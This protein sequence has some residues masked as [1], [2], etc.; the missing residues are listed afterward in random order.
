MKLSEWRLKLTDGVSDKLKRIAGLS[1]N[2]AMRMSNLQDR[3][4]AQYS[5]AA[6]SV[7]NITGNI[8]DSLSDLVSSFTGMSGS[9]L[10]S[11]TNPFIIASVIVAGLGIKAT[12]MAMQ[13]EQGM[14]KVNATAQMTS[15]ELGGLRKE[16]IDIGR[17]SA[18]DMQMLPSS[19]EKINSQ[20]NNTQVSLEVLKASVKAADAGFA[21]LDVVSGAVARTMNLV[22]K[23]GKNAQDVVDTFMMAKKLGAGEFSDFA[24]YMPQLIAAGNNL[25]VSFANTAGTFAY[26][27]AMGQSAADSA[28][29]MQNMFNMLGRGDVVK[30]LA[31]MGVEVFNKDGSMRQIDDIF[32]ALGDK[33]N[34]MSDQGKSNLLESLG[35][36]DQQAKSAFSVMIADADKLRSIMQGVGASSGESQRTLDATSNPMRTISEIGNQFKGFMLDIGYKILPYAEEA[37]VW[38]RDTLVGVIGGIKEWW[39]QATFTK[40]VLWLIGK[41]FGLIWDSVSGIGSALLWVYN[42]TLGPILDGLG[43]I[44]DKLKDILGLG[45]ET[46]EVKAKVTQEQA[47]TGPVAPD[48]W[49]PESTDPTTPTS[50]GFSDVS[51]GGSQVRNVIVNMKNEFN[52]K[53]ATIK[54]SMK[55]VEAIAIETVVRIAQG[56]ELTLA[57]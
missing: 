27:T 56:A 7:R 39:A 28:M 57:N 29:L 37:L 40:D 8:K 53:A 44:Y 21:D 42:H 18:V 4:E 51:G 45:G 47:F 55:E 31:G 22:A 36:K 14:A 32:V 12:Q 3:V 20:I 33:M 49:K 50:K 35:I 41:A 38:V 1:D 5:S 2:A 43:W 26:M 46:L 11:L 17:N 23:E 13:F 6:N 24:Q 10:T 9:L 30:K 34:T 54:E 19:F 25:G 15:S 48:G 16:I 52:I